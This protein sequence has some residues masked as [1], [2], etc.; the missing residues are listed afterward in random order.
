[1]LSLF[2][3]GLFQVDLK[4]VSKLWHLEYYLQLLFSFITVLFRDDKIGTDL[5]DERRK[6][7]S[8]SEILT[9]NFTKQ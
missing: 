5:I 8:F 6:N 9:R 3:K 7:T 4:L 1:M 2:I